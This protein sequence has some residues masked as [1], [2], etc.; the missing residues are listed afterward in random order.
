MLMSGELEV[1]R[2][3]GDEP[4]VRLGFLT[5]GAFF[6]EAAIFAG[7][8]EVRTRTVVAVTDSDLCFLTREEIQDLTGQYPELEARLNRF[9][10][11]GKKRLLNKN[12]KRSEQTLTKVYAAKF[13]EMVDKVRA[14]NREQQAEYVLA[15][16]TVHVG[17]VTSWKPPHPDAMTEEGLAERFREYG[18]VI[19]AVIRYR[20]ATVEKPNNSWALVVF[21]GPGGVRKLL[22]GQND[23]EIVAKQRNGDGKM[24]PSVN[25]LNKGWRHRVRRIDPKQAMESSGAFEAVFQICRQRVIGVAQLEARN[26]TPYLREA[27]EALRQQT[28]EHHHDRLS[29]SDDEDQHVETAATVKFAPG[30]GTSIAAA[31]VDK[32]SRGRSQT[33]A[34]KSEM[35]KHTETLR[36][37]LEMSLDL[38]P[39][40]CSTDDMPAEPEPEPAGGSFWSFVGGDTAPAVP[41]PGSTGGRSEIKSLDGAPRNHHLPPFALDADCTGSWLLLTLLHCG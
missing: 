6:G 37:S 38:V 1:F 12:A 35:T 25:D 41:S 13:T 16:D 7:G 15:D 11:I 33:T 9:T 14:H 34:Q 20:P 3:V 19:T 5:P 32:P 31:A 21:N 4:R 2:G 26:L 17:Q 29:D 8:A 27:A 18:E 24:N 10:T 28:L 40:T 39:P 36:Q 22:Q 23:T 30:V